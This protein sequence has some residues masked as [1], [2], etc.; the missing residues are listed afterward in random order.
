MSRMI[1]ID[2]GT[3]FRLLLRRGGCNSIAVQTKWL[4]RRPARGPTVLGAEE[5]FLKEGRF[6]F[7]DSLAIT[8]AER[9]NPWQLLEQETKD[10][11]IPVVADGTTL[12]YVLHKRVGDDMPLGDTGRRVRFVAA[13]RPGLL[14]SELITSER[15]FQRAFPAEDGYRFFLLTAPPAAKPT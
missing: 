7:Q 3:T 12:D 4:G 15:H 5:S 13:L 10:G 11:T 1:G 2:L 9:A 8:D 14:Q 6:A